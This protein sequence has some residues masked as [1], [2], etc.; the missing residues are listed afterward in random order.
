MGR[1]LPPQGMNL[2]GISGGPLLIL[3]EKNRDWSFNIG[4]VISEMPSSAH[5]E[6][7]I[8]EPVHFIAADGSVLDERSAPIQH[9]IK[10]DTPSADI[11]AESPTK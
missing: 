9:Y 7:V 4:G 8:V 10:A 11:G 3:T 1:G 5:F 6:I 2:G